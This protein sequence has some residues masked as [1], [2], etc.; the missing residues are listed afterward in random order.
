MYKTAMDKYNKD[1]IEDAYV[2]IMKYLSVVTFIQKT[3]DYKKDT[4]YYK[5]MM[6]KKPQEAISL[7]EKL[8]ESLIEGY[9]NLKNQEEENKENANVPDPNII[10]ELPDMREKK[11]SKLAMTSANLFHL[12]KD[13]VSKVLVI[14]ARP[15]DDY[16]N[17][18]I[19]LDS[20]INIPDN[21]I[22][23]G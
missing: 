9:K 23:K 8:Q 15:S 13:G 2:I 21:I 10:T 22:F 14:D 4:T 7:A 20:T 17:S 19:E 12:L 11:E 5:A 1:D 6:G 16:N 18:R 3:S